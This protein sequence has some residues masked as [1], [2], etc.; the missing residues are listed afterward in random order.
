MSG[1]E[2]TTKA[3]L[4]NVKVRKRTVV[5]GPSGTPVEV[6]VTGEARESGL[7][8]ED[9]VTMGNVKIVVSITSCLIQERLLT[10]IG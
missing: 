4:V 8:L 5:T 7:W 10:W 2:L 9:E 3:Q 6:V 1:A